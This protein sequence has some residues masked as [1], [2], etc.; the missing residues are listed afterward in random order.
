MHPTVRTAISLA[1]LF[2]VLA[3]S[4]GSGVSPLDVL[5]VR[6]EDFPADLVAPPAPAP[7]AHRDRPDVRVFQLVAAMDGMWAATFAAAGDEYDRPTVLASA[8]EST[9]GCGARRGGWAGVYCPGTKT[10]V[11]D[12]GDHGVVRAA[13]G[14]ETA[15]LVLAYVLAHEVGHHVQ[16]LRGAPVVGDLETTRRRELHADCLAGVWGRAAGRPLP[17]AEM[18][19]EDAEHGSAAQQ[20]HWLSVGHR[21]ARPADCDAVWK[22]AVA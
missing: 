14:D 17:P 16:S 5:G 21:R 8:R 2:V 19:G 22:A 1:V 18:H 12:L 11:I 7:A 6:R 20:H 3:A 15:D 13:R 9:S 4:H 10:I